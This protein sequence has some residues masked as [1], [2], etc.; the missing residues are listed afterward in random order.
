MKRFS[1][2]AAI[3]EMSHKS[4]GEYLRENMLQR[5]AGIL[6]FR[7]PATFDPSS[8]KLLSVLELSSGIWQCE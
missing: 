4:F 6:F 1:L 8:R 3:E 2:D 7:E 5:A